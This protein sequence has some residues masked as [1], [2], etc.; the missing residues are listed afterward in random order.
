MRCC[1]VCFV[2]GVCACC[3]FACV[4]CGVVCDVVWMIGF[5]FLFVWVIC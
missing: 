4:A 2:R 1:M 3:V 5:V